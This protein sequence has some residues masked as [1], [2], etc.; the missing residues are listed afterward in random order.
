MAAILRPFPRLGAQVGLAAHEPCS[1]R[2]ADAQAQEAGGP[3][4]T[5]RRNAQTAGAT[6]ALLLNRRRS[7]GAGRRGGPFHKTSRATLSAHLE[8]V[9][10]TTPIEIWFQDEARIGQKNGQVRQWARR[11]T[12]PRQPA[13]QRYDN[14]YLFGAI[15]PARGVGA[16]LALPTPTPRRC[17]STSTK[18]QPGSP[19]ALT[20][21]CCS[22]APDGTPPETSMG[23]RTSRRS[24]CPR[25]LPN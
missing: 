14:A 23:P 13:D 5:C 8:G 24:S 15:C 25:A 10:D 12:R 19:R 22:T 4:N 9:P 18:S 7:Y 11:G 20:P 2:M 1:G 16:A 3:Q 17:N 6:S 21:C